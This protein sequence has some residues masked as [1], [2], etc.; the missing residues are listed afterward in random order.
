MVARQCELAVKATPP[1]AAVPADL[2]GPLA[3]RTRYARRLRRNAT[4][5]SP[6]EQ[7]DPEQGAL[8]LSTPLE[9]RRG[10]ERY[11]RK[12]TRKSLRGDGLL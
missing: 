6:E 5:V 3:A 11:N 8:A 7:P 12:T 9:E 4:H 10:G 1:G 2:D